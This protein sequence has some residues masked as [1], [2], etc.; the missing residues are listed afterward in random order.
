MKK[1]T[2]STIKSYV[3]TGAA[4]DI[5]NYS[6]ETMRDFIHAHSLEKIAYSSG[7]YG[8][9]GGLLQ[10]RDSGKLYAITVRN[11]ALMMAF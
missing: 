11:S 10:D 6:F 2:Q 9:N 5:T 1:T 4:V 7:L 8:I 3:R